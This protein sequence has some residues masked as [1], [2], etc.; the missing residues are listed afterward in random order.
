MQHRGDDHAPSVFYFVKPLHDNKYSYVC[1]TKAVFVCVVC[2]VCAYHA[3]QF[4]VAYLTDGTVKTISPAACNGGIY[5]KK[6]TT[7]TTTVSRATV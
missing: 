5:I 4:F 7:T 3:Q 1:N 2:V 6:N